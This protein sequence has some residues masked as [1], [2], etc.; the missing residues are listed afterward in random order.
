[1]LLIFSEKI[2][3][4]GSTSKTNVKYSKFINGIKSNYTPLIFFFLRYIYI[5]IANFS[6]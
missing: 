5:Y 3:K 2:N 1:M 4:L 6:D